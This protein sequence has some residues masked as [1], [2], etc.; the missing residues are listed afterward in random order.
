M[1]NDLLAEEANPATHAFHLSFAEVGKHYHAFPQEYGPHRTYRIRK[2][3]DHVF[4]GF[5]QVMS[6]AEG[7]SLGAM[8]NHYSGPFGQVRVVS[9]GHVLL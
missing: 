7:T 1:L 8:G 6:A 2:N 4:K 9:L 5:G 3:E